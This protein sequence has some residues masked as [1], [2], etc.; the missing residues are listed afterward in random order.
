M[1]EIFENIPLRAFK[2]RLQFEA[3]VGHDHGSWLGYQYR[4][5]DGIFSN[6]R[7]VRRHAMMLAAANGLTDLIQIGLENGFDINSQDRK[8][9]TM[10]HYAAGFKN[11]ACVQYLIEQNANTGIKDRAGKTALDNAIHAQD[12]DSIRALV[13][14]EK[15]RSTVLAGFFNAAATGKLEA[16][17]VIAAEARINLNAKEKH[18]LKETVLH[19]AARSGHDHVVSWLLEQGVAV[20]ARNARKETALHVAAQSR[21]NSTAEILLDASAYRNAR[22]MNGATPSMKAGYA[23]SWKTLS[24][25]DKAQADMNRRDN[26]GRTALHYIIHGANAQNIAGKSYRPWVYTMNKMLQKADVKAD[27]VNSKGNDITHITAGY[28]L[29]DFVTTMKERGLSFAAANAQGLTPYALAR[30]HGHKATAAAIDPVAAK[31]DFTSAF[32][33]ALTAGLHSA[34]GYLKSSASRWNVFSGRSAQNDNG[35]VPQRHVA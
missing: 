5:R 1:I 35:I 26:K 2:S 28:G 24:A 33:K 25:L 30:Y 21:H 18:G 27:V 3:K 32:S 13:H 7:A 19:K 22:D 17:Q 20:N 14:N 6:S 23:G 4:L 8:G 12:L 15:S 11:S 16:L 34:S 31:S 9:K 10:L 29:K